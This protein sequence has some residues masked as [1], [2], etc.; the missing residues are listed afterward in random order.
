MFYF[1]DSVALLFSVEFKDISTYNS[2][3]LIVRI[4]E[5]REPLLLFLILHNT[6]FST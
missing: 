3:F 1:V 5:Q 6:V 2:F 4:F